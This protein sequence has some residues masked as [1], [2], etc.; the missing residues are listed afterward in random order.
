MRWDGRLI[1]RMPLFQTSQGM[2]ILKLSG[3]HP[4][5][6]RC[7]GDAGAGHGKRLPGSQE[8]SVLITTAAGE[9]GDQ[10]AGTQ[11][12]EPVTGEGL[13]QRVSVPSFAPSPRSVTPGR[14][15]LQEIEDLEGPD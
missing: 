6:G 3:N 14:N 10:L 8:A 11:A 2:P 15:S 4:G 12:G 9:L 13:Q 1:Q 7:G 5:V